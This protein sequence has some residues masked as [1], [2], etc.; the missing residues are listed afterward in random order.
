M[1]CYSAE[2]SD[3]T[4]MYFWENKKIPIVLMC[5][6]TIF[7]DSVCIPGTYFRDTCI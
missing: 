4:Q 2:E 7:V 3:V 1:L 5:V 6:S